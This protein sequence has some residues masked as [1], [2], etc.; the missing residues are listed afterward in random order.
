MNLATWK[1]TLPI[2]SGFAASASVAVDIA[3][4]IA[5]SAAPRDFCVM[6]PGLDDIHGIGDRQETVGIPRPSCL[7]ILPQ[8]FLARLV[9]D[10][11]PVVEI[12]VDGDVAARKL[13]SERRQPQPA[14]VLGAI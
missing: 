1:V 3:R 14:C 11:H 10:D 2:L 4:N 7:A 8:D 12:V 13:E 6:S 9:D 5:A